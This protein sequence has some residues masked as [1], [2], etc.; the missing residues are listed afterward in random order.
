[1]KFLA[2]FFILTSTAFGQINFRRPELAPLPSGCPYRM[3][4]EQ[5]EGYMGQ[6]PD[7]LI[8]RARE[9]G[10]ACGSRVAE[11]F[12]HH[13]A[14]FKG[15]PCTGGSCS[16]WSANLTASCSA[17][18]EVCQAARE[19]QNAQAENLRRLVAVSLS[20]RD[21]GPEEI[22]RLC[23]QLT[24][25]NPLELIR[26]QGI[27]EILA[28]MDC[29]E[30]PIG[31]ARSFQSQIAGQNSTYTLN[32]I[33]QSTYRMDIPIEF[34][35]SSNTI[36]Q[37]RLREFRQYVSNCIDEYN[38]N[39]TGPNGER[40]SIR[41]LDPDLNPATAGLPRNI[42]MSRNTV[43]VW[44]TLPR[45]NSGNYS[46]AIP[47]STVLHEVLHLT[48]LVDE[49]PEDDPD[50]GYGCRIR[51]ERLTIMGSDRQAAEALP[52]ETN[53]VVQPQFQTLWNQ[54][55][56][57]ERALLLRP[58]LGEILFRA[59]FCVVRPE[60]ER[61]A[62][63][64]AL[65]RPS[66]NMRELERSN[67]SLSFEAYVPVLDPETSM[68]WMEKRTIDCRCTRGDPSVADGSAIPLRVPSIL[69]TPERSAQRS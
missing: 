20:Q 35:T 14:S 21:L 17:G 27:Q 25:A 60:T 5:L 40:L 32:R 28:E 11:A 55:S 59:D 37:S 30:I 64:E 56:E 13:I 22:A 15:V 7:T 50:L 29:P 57:R 26:Q 61:L 10:P 66:L 69:R 4:G 34:T 38:D 52:S 12:V 51:P 9:Q 18:E 19:L 47:C 54:V 53:C 43:Q 33:D 42:G 23:Q 16:P 3:S 45:E 63:S 41:I 49:Y 6:S 58:Q 8:A 67:D 48:G 24:P 36:D 39:L 1:M 65:A 31:Q 2:I 44:E 46:L 68:A 62:L